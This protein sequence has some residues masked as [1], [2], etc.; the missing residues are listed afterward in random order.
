[1]NDEVDNTGQ[2]NVELPQVDVL[3]I[4]GGINGS[5]IARDAAGRGMTVT[6]CEKDD[7]A[8]HTSSASTKLIHGGLRY[9]EYYDFLLVR[10][11][12]QEREVLLR[13]APHIIWPLR[14]LLPHHKKMRPR[15]FIRL[16]L[17]LYDHLGGRKLLPGC[18]SVD[19][20][21]HVAGEAL[22]PTFTHAFEYSDCWVQDARLVVLNV[23]DACNRGATVL[24]RT[25]CSDLERRGSYWLATLQDRRTDTV[26][27]LRARAVVN[28]AGPWVERV[29][30]FEQSAAHE[31]GVR[32]VKGSH[33]VVKKFF[34]HPFP[35][36]FQHRDGRVVFAIPYE[37]DYALLGTTDV[38]IH[39]DPQNVSIDAEEIEYI[40]NA[41]SEYFR[42]SI[43]PSDVVWSYS[44]V[45]PL[46]DDA[47][48]NASKVTRDYVLQLD[49]TAAPI[50]SVFGGKITTYRKL[51]E[52]VVDMLNRSL[53]YS[54]PAWTAAASLPGGEIANADFAGFLSTCRQRFGW[55]DDDVLV[56]YARNYGSE[57]DRLL[58][59]KSSMGELGEN[60]GG[61]LYECELEYLVDQEWAESAEDVLWRRT[62]KGLHAPAET[63]SK[64]DEWLQKRGI[65]SAA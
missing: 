42:Q 62:K 38:E 61:G 27:Q 23:R 19:L 60:F 43:T 31:Y 5:G 30:R 41:V 56:D 35:Y 49:E 50:I 37:K 22:K 3:V 58:H 54:S 26:S 4:G 32:L 47:S 11:A 21:E 33:I 2:E 51:A 36:I 17:F 12:L 7:L 52:Q 55:L 20:R 48:Q 28:A 6:L 18:K 29:L 39:G 40:C 24:T 8:Q 14:F 16:G 63:T 34:D 59:G 64:V 9:L 57:I 25:N 13:A 1:M 46:F 45:R 53:N 65:H 15:W 10:H 44:G